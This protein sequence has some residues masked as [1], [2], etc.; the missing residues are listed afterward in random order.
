M[1]GKNI[2]TKLGWREPNSPVDAQSHFEEG[3]RLAEQGHYIEALVELK[4]AI[5]ADPDCAEAQLEIGVT[6]QKMGRPNQAIKAYL[7]ALEIR[8]DLVKAYKNLGQRR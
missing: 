6:Y 5:R 7:A 4:Q 3:V 8:A 1:L 2:L